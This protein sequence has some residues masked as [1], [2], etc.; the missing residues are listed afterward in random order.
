MTYDFSS[1]DTRATEI[2]EWLSKEF[3][4]IRT[5]QASPALLD[6][7]K[8]ESYGAKVPINQAANVGIEDA[9]TLRVAPWDAG[10]V[11]VIEKAIVD[12]DL[13]VSVAVDASGVRVLFPE[14]TTD[15]RAQLL[16]IAKSKLEEARVSI[17]GAR[18]EVVKEIESANKGGAMSDDEKFSAKEDLQK[19]VDVKNEALEQMYT[20]KEAEI[21]Q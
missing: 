12:A 2:V 20:C 13:G 9:R 7:V 18:D 15:R 11:Q 5:G 4:V 16:K 17:R 1:F 21:N 10:M 3:T 14:L 8:V 6:A 19:R